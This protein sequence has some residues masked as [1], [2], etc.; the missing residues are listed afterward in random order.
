MIINEEAGSPHDW[1]Y[2]GARWWR[3]DFHTHTPASLDTSGWQNA[4]G[5]AQE[6]SPETWL[7]KYMVAEIDC[8]AVTDHNTGDWIDRL[9][10]AYRQMEAAAENGESPSCFRKLHLFPGVEIS[11]QGGFHLLALFDTSATGQTIS[12][13]LAKVDYDG[14]RGDSDGVTRAGAAQVVDAVLAAG[15][16]PIPAHGDAA[17]GL[18][19]VIKDGNKLKIDTNTVRQVLEVSG[20]LAIEWRDP[21]LPLPKALQNVAIKLSKVIGSDCHS[22][23]GQAVPGSRYTW[24]KMARPSLEGLRLALLDGQG[25]SIRRS[26]DH[27]GFAPFDKPEHFIESI[28]IGDAQWMGRGR[29]PERLSFNPYFNA[30]IGGRGTGKST[31]IHALRLA[32]RREQ[33]LVGQSE[34]GQTFSSFNKVAKDS[35]GGGGLRAETQITVQFHRDGVL[36]RLIWRQDRNESMIEEWD[37]QTQSFRQAE[38]QSVSAQRFPLRLFSQ[39]QIAALAG[40]SQAALLKVI[41]DAAGTATH[42]TSFEDAKRGFLAIRAQLRELESKLLGRDTINLQL[43]DI[44][45]KL[46]RFEGTGHA[47][48]LKNYQRSSRQS[49]ELDRQFE[50]ATDLATR[51][52]DFAQELL[53]EDLPHDLFDPVADEPALGIIQQL[54]D[55]ITNARTAVTRAAQKLAEQGVL[56]KAALTTSGWRQ[57]GAAATLAYDK[58][59]ADLMQ[60]GVGDP[61]EYGKLVQEKQRLENEA[62]RLDA[63]QKQREALL[64]RAQ[65]QNEAVKEAR[66]AISAHRQSFLN[67]ILASNQFVQIKLIPYSR[68]GRGIEQSL[69]EVLGISDGRFADDL[70]VESQDDVPEK[71][72]ISPLLLPYKFDC[73]NTDED[74]AAFEAA[75]INEVKKPLVDACKGMGKFGGRL[76]K[77]LMTE[78]EKRPEF[79]DHIRCWF[80]D[81]GLEV[82]YSRKGDGKNFMPI[83]QAS[84]GQRAA[85]MLAFLLSHGNEPLILDQPEDDLDNH[86]IYDLV[87]QQIRSNKQRRQLIIVTHNPNIV[88]NGDAELIHVLDFNHQCFVKQ[89]GSLQ[90]QDM[91]TEVCQVME[92]GKEAFERRYQRLGREG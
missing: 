58:L 8:V 16:I 91:R 49:R 32:C 65:T 31:V 81:D 21:V 86:L 44:Q 51:M 83:G 75:I 10:L 41:D 43:Q 4:I 48:I 17:K 24:V 2:P 26:D 36:C 42:H 88:V 11:V 12:D 14:T 50:V 72:I 89:S 63:L 37:A 69:R 74:T 33:E 47:D 38:S 55:E 77:F 61:N 13:L 53:G 90:D 57:Q 59:K 80:P 1:P 19:E 79:V 67:K 6:L 52:Q 39:G 60:Q 64:E 46:A 56:I 71:G 35:N 85:A 15:G 82:K 30:L 70:Y 68:D 27:D 40:D 29:K 62:K 9:K 7:R 3:F 78:T 76:K 5:T 22:F 84:A 28:E 66:R 18:L 34:A 45:R 87:V 73:K 92:G 25:V 54:Q 23:Q 20:L